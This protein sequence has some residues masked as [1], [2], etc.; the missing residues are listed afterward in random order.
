[1]T[2]ARRSITVNG[3]VVEVDAAAFEI[4]DIDEAQRT[5]ASTMAYWASVCGSAESEAAAADAHYR[6]WRAEATNAIIARDPKAPE[7]KVKAAIEAHPDFLRLK[8]AMANAT[9]N[10]VTSARMFD[11][12]S[13][14]AN[15]AQSVGAY[16]REKFSKLGTGTTRTRGA[17]P[18][19]RD[20]EPDDSAGEET[21][22][23]VPAD[24]REGRA[25]LRDI[26][27][28]KEARK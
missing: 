27:K 12:A 24:E 7:W 14:R 3:T 21:A 25:K 1:M 8:T 18:E 23:K 16:E 10:V 22:R 6:K 13:K 17:D 20:A 11:A 5:S 28:K 26:L 4:S 15:L 9:D 19:D 2:H